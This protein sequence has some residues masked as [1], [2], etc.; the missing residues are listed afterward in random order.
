M[1]LA[2][3][4]IQ[5]GTLVFVMLK[6]GFCY[7]RIRIVLMRLFSWQSLQNSPIQSLSKN[8]YLSPTEMIRS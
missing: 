8:N 1:E 5:C 6:L 4:R 3:D 7:K 2:Q